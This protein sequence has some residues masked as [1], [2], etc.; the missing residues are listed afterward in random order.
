MNELTVVRSV[1]QT[2]T[3]MAIVMDD[4]TLKAI[5]LVA[6]VKELRVVT[7]KGAG[8]FLK[9]KP[10]TLMRSFQRNAEFYIEGEDYFRVTH[11]EAQALN[12]QV[13]VGKFYNGRIGTVVFSETGLFKL[14]THGKS[15][16]SWAVVQQLINGFIIGRTTPQT[17]AQQ[18]QESGAKIAYNSARNA[19]SL[20]NSAKVLQSITD[21]SQSNIEIKPL[22]RKY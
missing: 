2:T 20:A 15:K 9:V 7:A 6:V 12:A 16:E 18:V 13:N 1:N 10:A 14:S 21:K 4:D 11:V 17:L 22:V 5:E 19:E 3:D 8:A